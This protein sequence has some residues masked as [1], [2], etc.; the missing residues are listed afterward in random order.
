MGLAELDLFFRD[1]LG[2]DIKSDH[3]S[4]LILNIP[5][6]SPIRRLYE[7]E[8]IIPLFHRVSSG[9]TPLEVKLKPGPMG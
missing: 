2:Q 8:A 1:G 5:F 7:P 6:F 3:D 4:L 9:K